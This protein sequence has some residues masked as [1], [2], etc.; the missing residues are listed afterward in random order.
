M[1]T[2]LRRS[3]TTRP[4]NP[5]RKHYKGQDR[6]VRIDKRDLEFVQHW[7]KDGNSNVTRMDNDSVS[8]LV[9]NTAGTNASYHKRH[10]QLMSI[11]DA[12]SLFKKSP[13]FLDWA[14]I[15]A[16]EIIDKNGVVKRV[17]GTIGLELFRLSWCPCITNA[18]QRDCANAVIVELEEA[19]RGWIYLRKFDNVRKAIQNCKEKNCTTHSNELYMKAPTSRKSALKYFL[20]PEKVCY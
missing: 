20:C 3:A 2:M 11:P 16:R 5:L 6:K 14:K 1:K 9:T 17:L 12:H 13:E 10:I 4:K 18:K 19:L 7:I 15:N 8:I